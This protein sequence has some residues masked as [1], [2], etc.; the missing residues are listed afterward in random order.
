MKGQYVSVPGVVLCQEIFGVN[1]VMR[2]CAELLAEEGNTLLDEY[3]DTELDVQ[4]RQAGL[5]G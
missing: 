4:R 5:R 2:E 3:V 1:Q